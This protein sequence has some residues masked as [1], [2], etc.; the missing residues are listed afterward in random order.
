MKILRFLLLA[1]AVTFAALAAWLFARLSLQDAIPVWLLARVPSLIRYERWLPQ[2]L[3]TLA[4]AASLLACLCFG[5]AAPAWEGMGARR[6][7][8]AIGAAPIGNRAFALLLLVVMA[9]AVVLWLWPALGLAAAPFN[10][11]L[12]T[13][14]WLAGIA[15]A[16]G[17]AAVLQRARD[18][19]IWGDDA[20]SPERSWPLLIPILALAALLY[21]WRGAWLPAVIPPATIAAGLQAQAQAE[22]ARSGLVAAGPSGQQ[23]LATLVTALAMATARNPFTGLLW[24][25]SA[26]ALALVA[27]TWLLGCELFRRAPVP[28]VDDDGRR[29]ALLAALATAILLPLMHLARLPTFLAPVLWGTLGLWALLRATRTGSFPMAA[30]AGLF[31]GLALLLRP[32]GLVLAGAGA[33]AWLSLA[34]MRRQ[35]LAPAAGGIGWRGF[36][37]WLAALLVAAAPGL[38]LGNCAAAG[39]AAGWSAGLD[40]FAQGA[41]KAIAAFNIVIT[42]PLVAPVPALVGPLLGALFLLALGGLLFHVDQP[43]GWILLGWLALGIVAAA[44]FSQ[45]NVINGGLAVLLPVC[46][47]ALAF[48]LDRIRASLERSLGLW[49]RSAAMLAAVGLLLLA[50]LVN[51]RDYPADLGTHPDTA[52]ATARTVAQLTPSGAPIA[53]FTENAATAWNAPAIRLAT[54]GTPADQLLPPIATGDPAAWPST[55]PA[56]THLLLPAE[57]GRQTL[58]LAQQRYP[59]GA[60]QV[61]RDAHANAALYVY[62]LGE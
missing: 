6:V 33:F 13:G 34:L 22:M 41:I 29:P 11:W 31:G 15:L 24:A 27:A 23:W 52:I 8:A 37:L 54:A 40:G 59:G 45:S 39:A 38:C 48:A 9:L 43:L 2:D 17:I 61:V 7:R 18:V 26:T 42:Q 62:T 36:W 21:L 60:L 25:G 50:A 14:L 44:P 32:S 12:Q 35:L 49:V 56:G 20:G 10:G 57:P 28:G 53:L 58:L 16:L 5:L 51:V 55:L 47:L 4:Q 30:T 1:L 46:G 19:L 3:L